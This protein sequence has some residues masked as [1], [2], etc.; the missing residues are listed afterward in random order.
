MTRGWRKWSIGSVGEVV[1]G[2][3]PSA[4]NSD[5]YG[6]NIPFV[7]PGDLG[8]S[9]HI[10]KSERTLTQAGLNSA[11][12]V[13]KGTILYT[14]IGATIGKSGIA[15][16]L[17]A[18]NQQI[19][20]IVCNPEV[21][22]NYFVYYQ[23]SLKTGQIRNLSCSQAIPIVNKSTLEEFPL[24]LPMMREQREIASILRTWDEAIERAK[25]IQSIKEKIYSWLTEKLLVAPTLKGITENKKAAKPLSEF[26]D[27]IIRRN[28]ANTFG[29]ELV[30][31][32][33]NTKGIVPM[34]EQTI[35]EDLSRYKILPP[36]SFAYNPMRINVGSIAMSRLG[37]D[38]LASPD[39]VLFACKEGVLDPDYFDHL[40]NTHWWSHHITES[41]T[42]SVRQ[43]IYYDDLAALR[44]VIPPFEQQKRIA[45]CL[46]QAKREIELI[47]AQIATLEKQK[48]G[49]MQK[50][51]TGEWR[52]KL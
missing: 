12:P 5:F 26:T 17:L 30:M 42:G 48:R 15:A 19:N 8:K 36:R 28:T 14:C 1:T 11:K 18:T 2:T 32:V 7:S 39:Y 49:L 51:L 24:L 52:V 34:R 47:E 33:S 38:V 44:I 40:C 35:A 45:N 50:L 6:G 10:E 9:V 16:K 29:R 21:A 27:E 22:D 31:G 20:A 13:P 41:G 3:T 4:S 25:Q 46:N 23:L 43:R 37:S